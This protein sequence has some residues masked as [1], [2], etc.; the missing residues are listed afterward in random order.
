[1]RH[2]FDARL[3]RPLARLGCALLATISALFAALVAG[4]HPGRVVAQ[5]EPQQ[6][7]CI[8]QRPDRSISSN[9]F[10]VDDQVIVLGAAS[11]IDAVLADVRPPLRLLVAC[12]VDG[13]SSPVETPTPTVPPVTLAVTP[14]ATPTVQPGVLAVTPT[15]TPQVAVGALTL[16]AAPTAAAAA[17]DRGVELRLYAVEGRGSVAEAVIAINAA[18]AG[19]SVVADPNY[20]TVGAAGAEPCGDP[21][22]SGGSPYSSGGSPYS[23]GGS[24]IGGLGRLATLNLFQT[25]WAFEHIGMVDERQLLYGWKSGALPGAKIAVG[26]FD[27]SPFGPSAGN[28][29]AAPVDYSMSV[30]QA[31]SWAAPPMQLQLRP[32]ALPSALLAAG[33]VPQVD[34]SDHGL[35]VAGLIHAIAPWSEI[36]LYQVLNDA[37]CG[38][39]YDLETA[40]YSFKLDVTSRRASLDGAVANLSLGVLHPQ[41]GANRQ[42][43]QAAKRQ[44]VQDELDQLALQQVSTLL[45]TLDE[46]HNH[47]IA[48]VAAAGNNSWP[49]HLRHAPR[50]P[51]LPAASPH[52]IGVAGSNAKRTRSCFS[53]WAELSAP[54]G[55]G[56]RGVVKTN[57]GRRQSI[58]CAPQA[59]L[60]RGNCAKAL[61][62]L[63]VPKSPKDTGYAYWSGTSFAA[64]LVT[65]AAV[66]VMSQGAP[67]KAPEVVA[68]ALKCGA[69]AADGVIHIP[70]MM[71]RCLT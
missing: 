49:D 23:S 47:N 38:D 22:S 48:V 33:A 60:C 64:P 15:A 67:W 66:M 39:L 45:R 35:F 58:G 31:V 11:A 42:V 55:D 44:R 51:N 26:V 1:M 54:A 37:A 20:L 21:Y 17:G 40:L 65:G 29:G 13:A 71:A 10:F 70:K 25:Q 43:K 57:A 9:G 8:G 16:Q 52:V 68:V 32:K 62:S 4:A 14:T 19:R 6:V 3:K 46:L 24:P 61:V 27:T 53:N 7:R 59:S 69:A 56:G 50:P 30:T 12:D 41:A 2:G 5:G 36:A 63:V 18:G 28:R 34:A